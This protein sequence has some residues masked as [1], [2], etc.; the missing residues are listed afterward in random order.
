[1]PGVAGGL[2]GAGGWL[3]GV[4]IGGRA[5]GE[6]GGG[7]MGAVALGVRPGGGG[8]GRVTAGGPVGSR[9]GSSR[10]VVGAAFCVPVGSGSVPGFGLAGGGG[11]V[12]AVPPPFRPDSFQEWCPSGHL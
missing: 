2:V 7:G 10:V 4:T 6:G 12:D 9:V 3:R 8:G 1:M 11:G 5:I